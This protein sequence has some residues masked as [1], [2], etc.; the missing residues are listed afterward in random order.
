MRILFYT[1]NPYFPQHFGGIEANLDN[2]CR[3]LIGRG[4]EVV[5]LARLGPTGFT[6]A[7][8]RIV[9]TLFGPL[10]FPDS[11]NGYKI[12]REWQAEG[13]S[14]Q[15][16]ST[17]RPD[18]V[19]GH[20]GPEPDLLF[21]ELSL[22]FPAAIHLHG[23]LPLERAD[24]VYDIGIRNYICCSHFLKGRLLEKIPDDPV[25]K[26]IVI[27]NAFNT[28]DYRVESSKD[29]VTF[30]NPVPQK[31]L[32]IALELCESLPHI[33]FQFV[34]AWPMS[35][36][37]EKRIQKLKNVRLV[38]PVMD[39]KDIYRRTRVLIVPSVGEEGAGRVITEAQ[40]SGI[41]VIGSDRGGIPE[42]IGEGGITLDVTE[43][44]AWIETLA[45]LWESEA[46]WNEFSEKAK[47]QSENSKFSYTAVLDQYESFLGSMSRTLAL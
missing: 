1:S 40:I 8:N 2:L 39:M 34:R 5:V 12:Y 45:Q 46:R 11:L 36:R 44:T 32:K 7:R 37:D 15:L 14:D 16:C 10:A 28:G 26:V 30:I 13:T 3:G 31:G 23:V 43:L 25:L 18:V 21:T 27:Y 22:R 33:P 41:P 38:G 47:L 19:V 9:K 6:W 20:A 24:R 42:T 29:F 17:F 35:P 4:H